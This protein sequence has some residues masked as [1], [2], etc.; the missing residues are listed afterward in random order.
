ME[1]NEVASVN[2][3]PCK[4]IDPG[5][6]AYWFGSQ[7]SGQSSKTNVGGERK[8]DDHGG[9]TKS[10]THAL[11]DCMSGNIRQDQAQGQRL[12]RSSRVSL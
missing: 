5:G 6:R 1:A 2:L 9:G 11:C 4:P 7:T 12:T 8:P 3:K 10:E